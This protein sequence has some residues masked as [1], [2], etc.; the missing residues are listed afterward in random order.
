MKNISPKILTYIIVS[1]GFSW[2]I[3]ALIWKIGEVGPLIKTALFFGFM[4]GPGL[5]GLICAWRFNKGERVKALG[6]SGPWTKWFLWAWVIGM[7]LILGATCLHFLSPTV[8]PVV[9]MEGYA[10]LLTE[11]GQEQAVSMLETMPYV[12]LIL[13]AQWVLLAPLLNIP[14][15]LSEELGWRGWLWHELRAKGF[16]VASFWIGLL[17]GLWHIPVIAMG[18]NYPAMPIWGPFLFTL[19]CILYSP[20]FSLVRERSKSVWGPCILHGTTNGAAALGFAIQSNTAMP[21]RGL[22]GIGGFVMM[23]LF[24]LWVYKQMP[25][26]KKAV[27]LSA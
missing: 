19:F 12:N 6:L 22:V 15:M 23:S 27:T 9:P 24:V 5:A 11:A 26:V 2:S 17:W 18:H 1:F 10:A 16:W 8:N 3:A 25:Y 4:C 21:W 14:L 7:V 13:I 20:I